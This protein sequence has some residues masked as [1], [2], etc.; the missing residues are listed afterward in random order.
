M[1]KPRLVRLKRLE[2]TTAA[3]ALSAATQ[4][5]KRISQSVLWLRTTV[6]TAQT[7]NL[8]PSTGK[9]GMY[10]IFIGV[11]ASGNKVIRCNGATDTMQGV[12]SMG[13]GTVNTF[14][15]ASNTNTITL[16]GTTT[17]GILGTVIELWDVAVGTWHVQVNSCG[18][19]IQATPFSNT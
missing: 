4:T 11:T 16:N 12:A 17:G 3:I 1:S 5:L 18:S 10:R 7:I 8:P 19:G 2:S 15:T 9:G 14:I 13:G 6:A